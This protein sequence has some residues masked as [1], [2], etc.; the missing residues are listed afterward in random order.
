M[1]GPPVASPGSSEA[2][3]IVTIL[4]AD[5]TGS[6]SLGEQL[7]PERLRTL[8]GAYFVAM[9]AVIESWGG[10]VEKYIGD[11]V[12]AV[13]G[14]PTVREDDAERALHAALEMRTRLAE[15]NVDFERQHH[16]TLQ[17]RIGVNSG[18]VVAP[19][20]DAPDH[21]LVA[22]DAVN[23]AARLEQ[24][25]EPGMIL[26]GERTRAAA[27]REFRFDAPM[28][29]ALKGKAQPLRASPVLGVLPEAARGVRGVRGLRAPLIG[30]EHELATL[31]GLLDDAVEARRPRMVVLYGPAGI[32][33]T[34]LGSEFLAAADAQY[35]DVS[36]LRGRCLAVGHGITY[37]AL[38]EILRGACEIGLD[39]PVDLV[40]ER[41][42]ERLAQLLEPLN[43][44]PGEVEVTAAAL[45]MTAGIQL[46]AGPASAIT[47]E[48][49][50]RAWP[51]FATAC[52]AN[53][54]AVWVVE[55]LHWAGEPVLEMLERIATRTDGSL[56]LLATAR[57]EFA[58]SHPGFPA[59]GESAAAI[60]LRPLTER[61][62]GEML[63]RLLEVAEIPDA[64]RAEILAKAEGNPFFVEEIIQRLIDEGALAQDGDRWRAVRAI[65]VA[66]I[67]DSVQALL[68]A[69][70]DALAPIERRALQEAA[71]I[72]RTFWAAPV[73]EALSG[74]DVAE[75]LISLERKGLIF[76]RPMSTLVGQ[77][78]YIFKHAL[79]RDVAYASLPKAR[80]AR[81]HAEVAAWIEKLAADRS[82]ELAELIAHHYWTAV[83]GDD[84]D[85]AWLD[86]PAAREDLRRR[87][88]AALIAAGRAARRRFATDRAAELH[89]QARSAASSDAER[90]DAFEQIGRDHEVAFH[91]D[92]ALAAFNAALEI[93]RRDPGER[94]RVASLARRGGTMVSVRAGSF[95][96]PPDLV[97]ADA[98]IAEGLAVVEDRRERATLLV[99][100]AGMAARWLS[101]RDRDDPIP[102]EQRVAAAREATRIADELDDPTLR[103]IAAD[104]LTDL[105]MVQGEYADALRVMEEALP[106][107]ERISSPARRSSDY[108]EAATSIF[109]F[110]GDVVR[111]LELARQSR[112]LA[113]DL[114][115][116]DQMHASFAVI[117]AAHALGEWD[118]VERVLDEHLANHELEATVRCI[119]I[120]GGPSLGAL[121]VARR[122]DTERAMALAR[123]SHFWE[124]QLPGPVEGL[125]AGALVASGA[126]GEGLKLARNVLREAPRWR[127]VEAA[128]AA[129][130]GLEATEA[131]DEL[132]EVIPRLEKL[133]Q[134]YPMLDALAERAHGRTL[135]AS[136]D[137]DEGVA[138]LRR[139]IAA[140]DRIPVPFEAARTREA[141][142][143]A[144]P[145][146]AN[147]L[148]EEAIGVYR[149]LRATPHLERAES[150][151]SEL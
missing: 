134:G 1:A 55:D 8:L 112:E 2:R 73:D 117:R 138:A 74:E 120:Q 39:E 36:V 69:R 116:H 52:A 4:F 19:I 88:F 131:W 125:V 150:R 82:D 99:A 145:A 21:G 96:E 51:R 97:S 18:E 61:Q 50:A 129:L 57:P 26:V 137:A 92:E 114:S 94:A 135:F 23:V 22:G 65:D 5:V 107:I 103:F 148:L 24:A 43:L 111:S 132:R 105:H 126:T 30:R 87:A 14:V 144:V 20:G 124:E 12:M 77:T 16:V 130:D 115:P 31:L 41:L 10:T 128:A 66:P 119:A 85:L 142:A 136:G 83:A 64:L 127:W 76:V 62:S 78:E 109:E 37:W 122:G 90:L 25:A 32:G 13:F 42:R 60:S 53:G 28:T 147:A 38:A 80:R 104:I 46:D 70:V 101:V 84:S 15:L 11:A 58:E 27:R 47:A 143:E 71:V 40:R 91:G 139:A 89:E 79:V 35:P 45:A 86:D 149:K 59:G 6:T 56:V 81:A 106:A 146:E 34:R 98:L 63:E 133:R 151:L 93:A 9:A 67:P 100:L 54:P 140:F 108:S 17:V 44:P 7:D 113:R 3:K 123:R 29:L 110:G 141:L 118:E 95:R 102:M 68:S 33:K 49:L 121:V 75:A 72:G 48:D